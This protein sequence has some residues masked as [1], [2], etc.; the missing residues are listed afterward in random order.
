VDTALEVVQ[1]VR[2]VDGLL[3][4]RQG[5][6]LEP[7]DRP[8]RGPIPDEARGLAVKPRIVLRRASVEAV[9]RSLAF[10]RVYDVGSRRL[11]GLHLLQRNPAGRELP[12]QALRNHGAVATARGNGENELFHGPIATD[13]R[14]AV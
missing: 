8:V 9:G 10:S 5:L 7:I 12:R 2:D 14:L 11:R 13:V 1:T 4:A 3:A 6:L